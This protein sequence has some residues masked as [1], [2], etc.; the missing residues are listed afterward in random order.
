MKK[1]LKYKGV[2]VNAFGLPVLFSD[3]NEAK[4]SQ[5]SQRR[6][7]GYKH[8][9]FNFS[10]AAPRDLIVMYDIPAGKRSERDW[11][12]YQLKKYNYVMIQKSVWVGPSPL[13]KEFI[14]YAESIGFLNKLKTLKLAKPY[15]QK[16]KDLQ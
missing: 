1:Y 4:R 10:N 12:R 8:F 2:T 7:S 16:D 6:Y 9:D 14:R 13:P 5:K 3:K 15:S 11:F